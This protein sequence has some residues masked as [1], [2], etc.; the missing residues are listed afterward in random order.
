MM[1][2][3]SEFK[4]VRY[5]IR[6]LGQIM[7]VLTC[8]VYA[9]CSAG[10]RYG[11]EIPGWRATYMPACDDPFEPSHVA[12]GISRTVRAF[13]DLHG[14]DGA[15]VDRVNEHEFWCRDWP[16]TLDRYVFPLS[17]VTYHSEREVH[18]ARIMGRDV[19]GSALSHELMHVFFN[20]LNLEDYRTDEIA[21]RQVPIHI[22]PPGYECT[23]DGSEGCDVSLVD[24]IDASLAADG[25]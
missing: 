24:S 6:R 9:G 20:M 22:N 7:P 8:A 1:L 21:G 15:L 4:R 17:G 13:A 16:I 3:R 18:V 10:V 14:G 25:L 12:A 11:N 2:Y 19:S 5:F 23:W